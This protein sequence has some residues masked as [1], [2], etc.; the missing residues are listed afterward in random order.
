MARAAILLATALFSVVSVTGCP[1]CRQAECPG[2]TG[3]Q[4][5]LVLDACRCCLVCAKG[6]GATCGM[7]LD[8]S[9]ASEEHLYAENKAK[10]SITSEKFPKAQY[11][12]KHLDDL[13]KTDNDTPEFGKKQILENELNVENFPKSNKKEHTFMRKY[14]SSVVNGMAK[15]RDGGQILNSFKDRELRVKAVKY[16]KNTVQKI[17]ESAARR[18]QQ[19]ASKPASIQN[20]ILIL[21]RKAS[22]ITGKKV[23]SEYN[24]P[25][26]I[27]KHIL[28][29]KVLSEMENRLKGKEDAPEEPSIT[30][31]QKEDFLQPL[32]YEEQ[33]QNK[34]TLPRILGSYTDSHKTRV[35][36][37]QRMTN[38]SLITFI[39]FYYKC[40][41]R[42]AADHNEFN[43]ED[44]DVA[45]YEASR[46]HKTEAKM[47]NAMEDGISIRSGVINAMG[48]NEDVEEDNQSFLHKIGGNLLSKGVGAVKG[49]YNLLRF[50]KKMVVAPISYGKEKVT[51]MMSSAVLPSLSLFNSLANIGSRNL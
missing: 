20:A 35:I 1:P 14:T 2:A 13:P 6:A 50:G 9:S 47:L 36:Y 48:D 24:A 10:N 19:Q 11:R 8:C 3:C 12:N 22:E 4:Q 46:T 30:K 34:K 31:N 28:T 51:N 38:P 39:D 40:K 26:A 17:M 27:V 43:E 15:A 25:T 37:G 44:L 29:K 16:A 23:E 33:H 5:G 7:G 41:K 45:H 49:G 18:L 21:G 32:S 42:D